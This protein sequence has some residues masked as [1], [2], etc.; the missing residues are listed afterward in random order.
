MTTPIAVY[1]ANFSQYDPVVR[2]PTYVNP[3]VDYIYF[4][5]HPFTSTIWQVRVVSPPDSDPRRASRY[6]FDQSTLVLPDYDI[7]IMHGSNANLTCDPETLITYLGECNIAAFVHPHRTSVY[8][9]AEAVISMGK[10]SADTVRPQMARY[11][12]D[13]FPDT[14]RLSTCIL[15]V[16]RN[17]EQIKALEQ[18]WHNEVSL[19]SHRDQLSFDYCRW[20]LNVPIAYIPGDCYASKHIFSVKG[21]G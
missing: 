1:T 9:E 14:A 12:A 2:E 21:H 19:G 4:T 11:R 7:T 17:C 18:L 6:Y 20:K 5:D 15:L 16:R 10:D 8:Q 3:N 13:G